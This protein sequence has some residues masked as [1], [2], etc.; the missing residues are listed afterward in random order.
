MESIPNFKFEL[1]QS[2]K[3]IR[4][5]LKTRNITYS[6]FTYEVHSN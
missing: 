2:D 4:Q 6:Q 1:V 5:I 3:L